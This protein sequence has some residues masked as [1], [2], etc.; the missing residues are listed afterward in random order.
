[1][2][3][4]TRLLASSGGQPDDMM[5]DMPTVCVGQL[6]YDKT[7]GFQVVLSPTLTLTISSGTTRPRASR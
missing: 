5:D 1:M 4:F 6:G 2:T 7:K 3:G